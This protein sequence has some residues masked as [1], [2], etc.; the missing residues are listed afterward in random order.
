MKYLEQQ[1]ES[2][3][4]FAKNIDDR[5]EY[6]SDYYDSQNKASKC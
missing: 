3:D 6:I 4:E 2:G 5:L 1:I